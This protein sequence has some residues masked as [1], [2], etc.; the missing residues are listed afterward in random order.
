MDCR[1]ALQDELPGLKR[2]VNPAKQ[3]VEAVS[4]F[5][6]LAFE[7]TEQSESFS[8]KE[9]CTGRGSQTVSVMIFQL[10]SL[11]NKNCNCNVIR[12]CYT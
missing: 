4:E 3:K 10:D 7:T 5:D 1:T 12:N 9:A 8:Q 2:L 6:S 11:E